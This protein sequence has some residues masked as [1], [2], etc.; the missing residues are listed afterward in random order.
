[1]TL[2]LAPGVAFDEARHEY[3]Y[4]GLQ[5]SGV[6][7]VIARTLGQVMPQAFVEEHRIEGIHV[8]KAVQQ[9][10]ETGNPGSVHPGVWWLIESW[11]A[12]SFPGARA[13]HSEVLVSDFQR[14]ASAV[15]IVKEI[16]DN[17]LAIYDVKK[18]VFKREYVTWQ[19]S[20]YR[21]FIERYAGRKVSACVCICMKDRE[22]YDIFPKSYDKVEGLLYG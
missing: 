18:G 3:W 20:I 2:T 6:T 5:L 7:G 14:Y 12:E 15:D 11:E 19:L 10:I 21:Y 1:M 16:T 9:W 13:V 8:H 4:K 17:S 22:Y